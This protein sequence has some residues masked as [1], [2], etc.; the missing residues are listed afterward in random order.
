[1]ESRGNIATTKAESALALAHSVHVE[2]KT[3][4]HDSHDANKRK[5]PQPLLVTYH[6][7][8]L[9]I[10]KIKNQDIMAAEKKARAG[11]CGQ[12]FVYIFV[13]GKFEFLRHS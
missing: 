6:S 2:R 7:Q 4:S 1:M 12:L 9:P 13:M 8:L 3:E 5:Q 11:P 10:L